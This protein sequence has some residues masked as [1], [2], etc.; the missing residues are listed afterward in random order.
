M[1]A[2][3]T[4]GGWSPH[5]QAEVLSLELQAPL[6]EEGRQLAARD[7]ARMAFV[8]ADAFADETAQLIAPA[9]HAMALH[10]CGELHPI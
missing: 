3:G 6:C 1:R 8:C 9:H 7:G 10:A 2:R 4:W 5:R